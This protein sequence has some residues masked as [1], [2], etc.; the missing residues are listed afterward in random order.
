[1][2]Y[3]YSVKAFYINLRISTTALLCNKICTTSL[4]L[5]AENG[6]NLTGC[7]RGLKDVRVGHRRHHSDSSGGSRD[8][9]S[10]N[11]TWRR[12][13]VTSEPHVGP[14]RKHRAK[15]G[16]WDGIHDEEIPTLPILPIENGVSY[17]GIRSISIM[18]AATREAHTSLSPSEQALETQKTTY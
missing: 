14:T 6:A 5:N 16:N 18:M 2:K 12:A 10:P 4:I 15:D 8:T 13:V 7:F 1:M 11:R 9:R 3:K 17:Q